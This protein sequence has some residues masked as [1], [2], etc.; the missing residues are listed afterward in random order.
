MRL[1]LERKLEEIQETGELRTAA[2]NRWVKAIKI[3]G[4][5]SKKDG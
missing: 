5:V 4:E 1:R 3:A 2:L